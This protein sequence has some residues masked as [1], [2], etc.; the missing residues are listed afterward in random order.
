VPP[1]PEVVV[2]V[3]EWLPVPPLAPL[4]PHAVN[5]M[6]ASATNKI[7]AARRKGLLFPSSLILII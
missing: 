7:G 4:D 6:P 2:V 1:E 3:P 5:P